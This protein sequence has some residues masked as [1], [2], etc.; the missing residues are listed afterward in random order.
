MTYATTAQVKAALAIGTADTADDTQIAAALAAAEQ[1]IDGY[2]GRSFGT[3][4]TATTSRVYAAEVPDLVFIDDATTVTLVETDPQVNGTW[5]TAWTATD[6]QAEPLNNRDGG[7]TVPYTRLA[8]VGS[9]AFPVDRKAC[10]RVTG[11]WGWAAVPDAVE[12]AAIQT[13][14]RLWKRLDTPLGFGGGPDTGLLYVSRQIDGDVAQLLAPYRLGT[15]AV[16][17][18]A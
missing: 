14:I 4:G 8:A 2:C 1:M 6:W 10:V 16:G 13:A 17:G 18:I 15:N 11:T 5:T 9:Y 7:R 12:Q 3:A